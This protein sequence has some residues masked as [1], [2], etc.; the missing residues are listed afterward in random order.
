M[1]L[2]SSGLRA[3]PHHGPG[4]GPAARAD[5]VYRARDFEAVCCSDRI[6]ETVTNK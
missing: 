5:M 1:R 4:V 2:V 6:Q 3:V